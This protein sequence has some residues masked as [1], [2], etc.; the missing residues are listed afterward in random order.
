M[1]F[2]N[3]KILAI[4]GCLSYSKFAFPWLEF[5]QLI[6]DLYGFDITNSIFQIVIATQDS[7]LWTQV[8]YVVLENGMMVM[9]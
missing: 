5:N 2:T 1:W 7:S 4:T 3:I 8:F 9:L 6:A